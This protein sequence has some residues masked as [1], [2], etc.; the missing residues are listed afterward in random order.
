MGDAVTIAFSIPGKPCA[1]QSVRFTRGGHRYQPAD[2][3]EYRNKVALFARQAHPGEP[4]QG[5]I[6][7]TID[8]HFQVPRSWS[9]KRQ[10]AADHHAQRPDPDNIGKAILDGIKGVLMQDDAQVSS[11]SVTKAWC[12]NG[13]RVDVAVFALSS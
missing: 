4:L 7:V 2:V 10:A 12:R 8:A 5:P 3:T 9:K 13:E 6:A 1:K 11:L